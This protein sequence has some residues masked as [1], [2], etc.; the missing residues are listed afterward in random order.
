MA[1]EIIHR[2]QGWQRAAEDYAIGVAIALVL[3]YVAKRAETRRSE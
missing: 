1:S 2:L 3:T